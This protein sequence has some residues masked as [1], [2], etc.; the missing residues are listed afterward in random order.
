MCDVDHFKNVN[1]TYGHAIGDAV[2]RGI[3]A[4]L[5]GS[6][7]RY[8]T[9]GRFGGEEFIAVLPGCNGEAATDVAERL[10]AAVASKPLHTSAGE[11]AVTVSIGVASSEI[12]GWTSEPIV[13]A[14]DV[15]L[16]A[17]KR[18]GRNRV[19]RAAADVPPLSSMSPTG[20]FGPVTTASAVDPTAPSGHPRR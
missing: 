10:R 17:A 3:A 5:R 7:R 12:H 19:V 4:R 13:R 8:D 14:S 2:L 6:C 20:E 15:A 16:Y 11:I 18:A 9:V 1:D